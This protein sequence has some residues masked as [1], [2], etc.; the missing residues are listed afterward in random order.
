MVPKLLDRCVP[1]HSNSTVQVSYHIWDKS[2]DKSAYCKSKTDNTKSLF[3]T[4]QE[5]T[6][7][8]MASHQPKLRLVLLIVSLFGR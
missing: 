1:V 5:I 3:S 7:T 4:C 2:A 6:D 8:Q